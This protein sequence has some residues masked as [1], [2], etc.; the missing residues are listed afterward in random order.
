MRY[1]KVK[2]RIES[3]LDHY[4]GGIKE[5]VDRYFSQPRPMERDV[6]WLRVSLYKE[7]KSVPKILPVLRDQYFKLDREIDRHL[8]EGMAYELA[9]E[10][11]HYRLLADTLEWL[12]GEKVVADQC[13]PSHEQ[14][15]LEELRKNLVEDLR[16]A[17]HLNVAHETVFASVMKNIS[18]GE[19]EKRI[20]N[21]Y[22]QVFSDE[23]NHYKL[24]WKELQ[25]GHLDDEQLERI[26]SANKQVGRQYLVM[27]NELFGNVLSQERLKEIDQGSIESYRPR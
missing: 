10:V 6:Y 27:R 19:L 17:P 18:G 3:S 12:T 23:V 1:P 20:A 9:D 24:G 21:S 22:R 11:K 25:A 5:L 7:I 2:D 15:K 26:I 4:W 14:T 8:Y 13:S 16:L